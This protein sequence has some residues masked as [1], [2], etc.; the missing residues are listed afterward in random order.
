QA[1][2]D[3]DGAG[4]ACDCQQEDPYDREPAEAFGL[5]VSLVGAD[6]A[7]LSW[8]AAS[9]ADVYSVS[10][11]DLAALATGQYGACLAEGLWERSLEDPDQPAAGEGF[12]YMV[13]GQSFECGL[14]PLGYSSAEEPRENLDPGACGGH[15]HTDARASDESSVYGTVS[16]SYLDTQASDDTW[17]T[18]TE[19]LSGGNP[20]NRHSR[21]EQRWTVEV[22]TGGRV[23]LHVEAFR[24]ASPDGDGFVFE[25]SEDGGASWLPVPLG[26]L[27]LADD[28]IDREA[29]LSTTPSGTVLVR[30][31]DTDR[32]AGAQ[33]LD[34][35]SVDELFVRSVP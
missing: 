24:T 26:A 8:E 33:D 29:V 12:F 28:G 1:D 34:T 23:E 5:S 10:R 17:E 7:A 9:G 2:S 32:T 20:Q 14:G 4:D 22:P 18:I 27:P 21:L 6:T 30:V 25:Y 35:V 3:G 19:E 13:Q 16:G 15:P 11:G 31:V